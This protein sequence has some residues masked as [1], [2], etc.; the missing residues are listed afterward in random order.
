VPSIGDFTA[1]MAEADPDPLT[2]TMEGEEFVLR[3]LSA[4]AF[5]KFSQFVGEIDLQD[6]DALGTVQTVMLFD[7]LRDSMSADD[8]TRFTRVVQ[9]KRVEMT[10]VMAIGQ[11]IVEA[12]TGRPTERPSDLPTRASSTSPKSSARSAKSSGGKSK[13]SRGPSSRQTA[14]SAVPNA[15][16]PMRPVKAGDEKLIDGILA[17][18]TIIVPEG[19]TG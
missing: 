10:T 12:Q 17:G 5:L 8:F 7:L 2:F 14:M 3:P 6:E 1:A 4:Y 16:V 15:T 11:S 9:D 19:S 13:R 18:E